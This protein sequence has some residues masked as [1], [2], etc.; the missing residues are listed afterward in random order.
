MLEE[1]L[2]GKVINNLGILHTKTVD[3]RLISIK[4]DGNANNSIEVSKSGKSMLVKTNDC[5]YYIYEV[6]DN[7]QVIDLGKLDGIWLCYL[8]YLDYKYLDG[9]DNKVVKVMDTLLFYDNVYY[10]GGFCVDIKDGETHIDFTCEYTEGSYDNMAEVTVNVYIRLDNDKVT[11]LEA[12]YNVGYLDEW[13]TLD[14]DLKGA[15]S[16]QVGD[17]IS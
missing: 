8:D 13:D 1:Y 12:S 7:V 6:G 10:T 11:E 2:G 5:V 14:S 15:L 4:L 3:Y 16:I 9:G 17:V